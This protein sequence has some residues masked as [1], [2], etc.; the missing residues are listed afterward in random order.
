MLKKSLMVQLWYTAAQYPLLE[1]IQGGTLH[2]WLWKAVPYLYTVRLGRRNVCRLKFWRVGQGLSLFYAFEFCSSSCTA[3]FCSV[4]RLVRRCEI[5][6][7]RSFCPMY[8]VHRNLLPDTSE[9]EQAVPSYPM[10]T[11]GSC[12]GAL[13]YDYVTLIPLVLQL[14]L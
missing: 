12:P 13:R 1:S 4:Q 5:Q 8:L 11:L 9:R 14:G 3:I 7:A 10:G 2:Q 6:F